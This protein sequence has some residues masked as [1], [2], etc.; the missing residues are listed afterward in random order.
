MFYESGS[1]HI[2][3]PT[4]VLGQVRHKSVR[5][6]FDSESDHVSEDGTFGKN[7]YPMRG[8]LNF[9]FLPNDVKIEIVGF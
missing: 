4:G 3:D 5:V 2:T 8:C 1:Y 9:W 7:F 6:T